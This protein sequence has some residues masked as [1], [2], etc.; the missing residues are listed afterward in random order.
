M[1]V[2]C[3]EPMQQ[4]DAHGVLFGNYGKTGGAAS[5]CCCSKV[6]FLATPAWWPWF[7]GTVHYECVGLSELQSYRG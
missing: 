2:R 6:F 3:N 4:I 7:H 5:C 1:H